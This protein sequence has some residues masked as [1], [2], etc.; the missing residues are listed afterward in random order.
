M[1]HLN[2]F[3][4]HSFAAQDEAL[5]RALLTV[6]NSIKA[7]MPGFEWDHAEAAEPK[8]LSAKVREKMKGK[9][10][11]IGICTARE[12]T[13]PL[14]G[15]HT[16]WRLPKSQLMIERASVETK[17]TDWIIQE[18][19]FAL[20]NNMEVILLLED[21]VRKP[22][23]LQ[24]DLEYIPFTRSEP[25]K[26]LTKLSSM[27]ATL[28]PRPQPAVE[29][30]GRPAENES[31]ADQKE[32][33]TIGSFLS[34]EPG[35]T[36]ETYVLRLRFAIRLELTEYQQKITE[37]FRRSP[38]YLDEAA[39]VQFEAARISQRAAVYKEDWIA[40]LEKLTREH[41]THP[42]PYMAFGERFAAAGEDE[43]AAEN[44]ELAAQYS[45]SPEKKIAFLVMAATARASVKQVLA[46]E[47]L[48]NRVSELI[49]ANPEYEAD[50]LSR[51]CSVWKE[52][53]KT[54]LFFVCA[55]RCL[56]LAP[57]RA[58]PRFELAYQYAELDR[59]AEALFHYRQYLL[60]KDDPGGW[61]NLGVAASALKLPVTAIDAY[62]RAN[63]EGN[64]L[65]TSNLAFAKLEAGFADEA[66]ELCN[67]ALK[68]VEEASPRLL[69][70]LAACRRAQEE[71]AT[72]ESEQL[73]AI[74]VRREMLRAT[75][76]ASLLAPPDRLP[77]T[78]NGPRCQ[79][80][81]TLTDSSV[82]MTGTYEQKAGGYLSALLNPF[83][84]N[85]LETVTVEYVGQFYGRAFV[86]K[87]KTSTPTS[88]AGTLSL[89]GGEGIECVGYLDSN[90][91]QLVI[92]EGTNRYAL[93]A[94]VRS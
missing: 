56:E 88:L 73:D 89:L 18:I 82:V 67:R 20:G 40:A 22:G 10:L 34:P 84:D 64:T 65:A 5:V 94:V 79:L 53:G 50:G 46:A 31:A 1:P 80:A 24:G 70:A 37:A 13:L 77:G 45:D 35:W 33:S 66:M 71:E 69:D 14:A 11:F 49:R 47:R 41:P 28:S 39:R 55:E 32:D 76:K 48:L 29:A 74:K 51:V 42:A 27:L 86:G 62:L 75:G 25:E 57:D 36:E 52:L 44:F 68:E 6:L 91:D 63:K 9:N 17:T 19:G 15:L 30:P 78:W 8:V 7:I 60:A 85:R 16:S 23:G 92:L 3:V 38:L 87:V 83:T 4:G 90:D 61:N 21:G 43:R 26:C 59:D 81:A 72:K 58:N 54:Q 2:A 93:S 12:R